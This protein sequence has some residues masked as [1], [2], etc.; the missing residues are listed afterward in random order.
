M[1]TILMQLNLQVD[2]EVAADSDY[3]QEDAEA[4]VRAALEIDPAV[5]LVNVVRTET[6]YER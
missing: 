5:V 4:L 1:D 6:I 2:V 3:R